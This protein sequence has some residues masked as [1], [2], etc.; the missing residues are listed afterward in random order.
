MHNSKIILVAFFFMLSAC[1]FLKQKSDI[2]SLD[3]VDLSSDRQVAAMSC[4]QLFESQ[5]KSLLTTLTDKLNQ[6]I[7]NRKQKK[8]AALAEAVFY[9]IKRLL[10][11]DEITTDELQKI[12]FY[13]EKYPEI[14]AIF[15]EKKGLDFDMHQLAKQVTDLKQAEDILF[16]FREQVEIL[17]EGIVINVKPQRLVEAFS[18]LRD[19][20]LSENVSSKENNLYSSA[21]ELKKISYL[22]K[23]LN[24]L[25]YEQQIKMIESMKLFSQNNRFLFNSGS[26]AQHDLIIATY[27]SANDV[28]N[29]NVSPQAKIMISQEMIKALKTLIATNNKTSG[30][31]EKEIQKLESIYGVQNN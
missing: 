6:W 12:L 7:E 17:K 20:K 31:W 30:T 27:L 18:I 14:T 2:S 28:K 29:T 3:H 22:G 19:L 25:N 21:V 10:E 23:Y 26:S 5:P 11:K 4:K 24:K 13:E 16:H 9:D 15:A 1:S 8:E